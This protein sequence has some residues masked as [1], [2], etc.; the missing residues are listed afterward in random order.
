MVQVKLLSGKKA[1]VSWTARRF[2]VRIGRSPAADLQLEENGVGD[3]HIQIDMTPAEGF[4][5]T[6]EPDAFATVNH[7][8]VRQARLRN[9]D[10][11]EIGSSKMQFGLSDT[12]QGGL[13]FR[14][15]FTWAGIA[16]IS[17]AQIGLVYWLL[18]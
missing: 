16:T 6:V 5:L 11:I 4:T 14:E 17:L 1:G 15:W 13:R 10:C 3:L 18:R 9:G 12:R 8:P 7:E 2:P